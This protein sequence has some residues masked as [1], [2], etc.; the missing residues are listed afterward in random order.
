ME[1]IVEAADRQLRIFGRVERGW[2][3]YRKSEAYLERKK[4]EEPTLFMARIVLWWNIFWGKIQ[5]E[6][7]CASRP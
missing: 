6:S 5:R 3:S 7:W 1:A 4:T 2:I